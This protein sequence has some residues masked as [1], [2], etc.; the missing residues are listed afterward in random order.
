MTELSTQQRNDLSKALLEADFNDGVADG[1]ASRENLL[2]VFGD[3]QRTAKGTR[4]SEIAQLVTNMVTDSGK[5]V[6]AGLNA[7]EICVAVTP[8]G[9]LGTF[10]RVLGVDVKPYVP[11]IKAY[12]RS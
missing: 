8:R 9:M 1:R 4:T 12:E 6:F 7:D 10:A 11:P 5:P 3:L 2:E